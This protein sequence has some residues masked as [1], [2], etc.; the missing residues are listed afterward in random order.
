[1]KT[2]EDRKRWE[3][4]KVQRSLENPGKTGKSRART[5]AEAVPCPMKPKNSRRSGLIEG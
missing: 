5:D 3:V 1:M 4:K 2:R